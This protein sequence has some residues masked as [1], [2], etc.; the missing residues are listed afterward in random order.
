L[1]F[2]LRA[3]YLKSR[4][5]T[6]LATPPVHFAL[7]I[8]EMGV[9]RIIC[10]CW[11]QT[12][13]PLISASQVARITGVS[14]WHTLAIMCPLK[15]KTIYY[16]CYYASGGHHSRICSYRSNTRHGFLLFSSCFQDVVFLFILGLFL[17]SQCWRSS[18]RQVLYQCATLP[19]LSLF[20]NRHSVCLPQLLNCF[21][22][23][24]VPIAPFP[25]DLSHPSALGSYYKSAGVNL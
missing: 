6:T 24:A 4:R 17:F 5:S 2:E 13:I 15:T 11:P 23:M 12:S 20:F 25:W 16:E 19:G 8:L 7:I 9:W 14:H 1:G 22:F 3:L 18:T 10:P 21:S